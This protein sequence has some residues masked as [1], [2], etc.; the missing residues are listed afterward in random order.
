MG[1]PRV[2]S[3]GGPHIPK[4]P[5]QPAQPQRIPEFIL[6][7]FLITQEPRRGERGAGA[8]WRFIIALVESSRRLMDNHGKVDRKMDHLTPQTDN[9][10]FI[11]IRLAVALG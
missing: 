4:G 3:L 7:D 5:L 9:N 6:W 8:A 2:C 10:S 11:I 1:R